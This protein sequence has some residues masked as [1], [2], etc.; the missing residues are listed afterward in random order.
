M[1]SIEKQKRITIFTLLFIPLILLGLFVIYP[2]IKLINLSFTNWNGI[3]SSVNYVGIDNYKTIITDS[4]NVWLSLRNNAT[5]FAIHL[6]FIPIE[7]FVAFL[8]DRAMKGVKFFK[9]I[10]FMPYIINGVAVSYMF[11]MLYS[12]DGGALNGIL[13]LFGFASV[14]WLSD[15]SIVNFSLVGVSLWKFS[16]FHIVLFL[17]GIQSIPLDM[18][19]AA[20][21]DGANIFQQ[22]YKI[23]LPNIKTVISLVLFTNVTGALQVFDIPFIM[24]SGGPGH[25]SS[26]FTLYTIETA[27]TYDKF[28]M[29]SAMA[30]ILMLIIICVS[31]VQNKLVNRG[32]E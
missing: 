26:T 25:A 29:A 4:P 6:L 7:L 16:G 22:F 18:L 32:E 10:V 12:S 23:V 11:A 28:G 15:I 27:F 14:K 2:T 24:T 30:V 31:F 3:S 8:L 13:N 19:E 5:Y 20:T 1:D 21:V 9:T 17:A